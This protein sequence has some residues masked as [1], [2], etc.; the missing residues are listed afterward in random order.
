MV[1]Y[2]VAWCFNNSDWLANIVGMVD[3]AGNPVARV[4]YGING[5]P[6]RTFLGRPVVLVEDS[7]MKTFTA[8]S[9]SEIFGF[10]FNFSDYILNSNMEITYKKYFDED[11]DLYYHKST[12]LCDGKVADKNSLVTLTK[13]A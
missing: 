11:T 12:M 5:M 7:G 3:T 13:S 9:T 4:N 10:L 6:E 8:A 2:N 1:W